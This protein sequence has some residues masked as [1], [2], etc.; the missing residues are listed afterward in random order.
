MAD[1]CG[2][3]LD[4]MAFVMRQHLHSLE[5]EFRSLEPQK[6]FREMQSQKRGNSTL[7]EG[8]SLNL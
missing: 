5:L 3:T 7:E 2:A 8:I 4:I 6:Y 1:E